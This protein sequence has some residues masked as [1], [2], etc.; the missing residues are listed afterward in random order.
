LKKTKIWRYI[1]VTAGVVCAIIAL[2]VLIRSCQKIEIVDFKAEQTIIN[3]GEMTRLSWNVKN[4]SKVEITPGLGSVKLIGSYFAE[5]INTTVYKLL[6]RKL[7]AKREAEL[8]VRVIPCI[9]KHTVR[10]TDFNSTSFLTGHEFV[11]QGIWKITASPRN[12]Y[13]NDAIPTIYSNHYRIQK[14]FLTTSNYKGNIYGIPIKIFFTH[15]VHEV[16]VRFS[17]ANISYPIEAFRND[18]SK[19]SRQNSDPDFPKLIDSYNLNEIKSL[20]IVSPEDNIA[21]I[22]FGCQA[23]LTAIH[24]IEF[25]YYSDPEE[26]DNIQSLSSSPLFLFSVGK[27]SGSVWFGGDARKKFESRKVGTG[28]SMTLDH[29][30]LVNSISVCFSG[31][32]KPGLAPR[33]PANPVNVSMRVWDESGTEITATDIIIPEYFRGGWVSFPFKKSFFLNANVKYMVTWYISDKSITNVNNVHSGSVGNTD[34]IYTKGTGYSAIVQKNS[35]FAK[36]KSWFEKPMDFLL[37][38]EGVR[39]ERT[40]KK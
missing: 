19:I 32:F 37:L 20:N 36:F 35:D 30:V 23:A 4:A 26:A 8:E 16:D 25:A 33:E 1:E 2:I 34:N 11:N 21:F 9:R 38:V 31:P 15:P 18:G 17:G 7:F 27:G 5:P 28:Q 14:S 24:E 6:A 10:F 13:G 40:D 22:I 3:Q 29:D 39:Q 12:T